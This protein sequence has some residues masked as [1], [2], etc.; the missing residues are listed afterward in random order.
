MAADDKTS[1]MPGS[2]RDG[3][4]AGP[5]KP[6]RTPV[7]ILETIVEEETRQSQ[8]TGNDGFGPSSANS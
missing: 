7:V 6:W 1:Q 4:R 8:F 5:R 2:A 3:M